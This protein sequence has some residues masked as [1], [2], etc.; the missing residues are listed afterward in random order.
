ML[1]QNDSLD[2]EKIG[3][4]TKGS[5]MNERDEEVMWIFVNSVKIK[6]GNDKSSPTSTKNPIISN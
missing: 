6:K 3:Y 1:L 2:Y 4:E 5:P